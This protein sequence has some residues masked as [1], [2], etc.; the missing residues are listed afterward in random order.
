MNDFRS[1]S[2]SRP[3]LPSRR[4]LRIGAASAV[5]GLLVA[6]DAVALPQLPTERVEHA[7][8]VSPEALVTVMN[9]AGSVE[10]RAADPA[11]DRILRVVAV[12]RATE[13]LSDEIAA[14]WFRRL[15]LEPE[16]RG[17]R[18]HIGTR[19]ATRSNSDNG[20]LP[21]LAV[22]EVPVPDQVPPVSV[23]LELWLPVGSSLEVRTFSAPIAVVRIGAPEAS[24]LL[25]SVSGSVTVDRVEADD[26]RVE[27]VSGTL[28]LS[29]ARARRGMFQ[30]LTAVIQAG[31]AF[32]PGGWYDFQT[33]S[34]PVL[35]EFEPDSS[36]TLEARTYQGEIV[37]ELP[38][39]G[40]QGLGSLELNV[41]T[42]G[43]DL[44]VNT[45]DGPIQLTAADS[46]VTTP[47]R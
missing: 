24:L 14:L 11:E 36:F 47:D 10:V 19:K 31:G 16:Q 5:A 41:G 13:D 20:G 42:G 4:R 28:R 21:D 9:F 35:L 40:V 39:T 22:A 46:L 26:L 6:A 25:R 3:L 27:T 38:F 7:V 44:R 1:L 23:D 43:A 34:G 12:K 30:T 18:V 45:F 8:E 29:D 37:N 15:D 2:E 32:H 17:R 33:H